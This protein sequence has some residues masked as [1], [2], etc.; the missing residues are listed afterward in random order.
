MASTLSPSWIK[1][2]PSPEV[3]KYEKPMLPASV[4]VVVVPLVV[5]ILLRTLPDAENISPLTKM[6]CVFA[7]EAAHLTSDSLRVV[8]TPAAMAGSSTTAMLLLLPR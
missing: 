6:A 1:I 2:L 5:S 8:G 3:M 7:P 4:A